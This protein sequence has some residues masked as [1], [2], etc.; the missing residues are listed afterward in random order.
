MPTS[1]TRKKTTLRY[2]PYFPFY[3]KEWLITRNGLNVRQRGAL[4]NLW[5]YAWNSEPP[6][7]LMDDDQVL[8]RQS[9][10]GKKW[11]VHAEALRKQFEAREGRLW[12]LELVEL[13]D[14]MA[15]KSEKRS[16][17]GVKG[18]KARWSTIPD[19]LEDDIDEKLGL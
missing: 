5:C 12:A 19:D 15:A 6:G 17:N 8:A 13:Y 18:A 16:Q 10:L 7:S 3:A 11:A 9:G 1:N 4:I 14:D 2:A